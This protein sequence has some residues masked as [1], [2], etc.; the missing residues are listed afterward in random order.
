MGKR[1]ERK[2]WQPLNSSRLESAWKTLALLAV[3]AFFCGS[4]LSV[5]YAFTLPDLPHPA[6]GHLYP[7][8]HH[9][10]YVYLSRTNQYLLLGL[11]GAFILS[12]LVMIVLRLV[13]EGLRYKD[14]P[15][16]PTR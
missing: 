2:A 1:W 15:R 3:A 8:A 7:M 13:N 10:S 11:F 12:M 5:Y 6:T 4:S 9:G 16:P 14:E